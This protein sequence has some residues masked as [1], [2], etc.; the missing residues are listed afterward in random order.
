MHRLKPMP[1]AVSQ[2]DQMFVE[3]RA[4]NKTSKWDSTR[5]VE[6]GRSN[7]RFSGLEVHAAQKVLEARVRAQQ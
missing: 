3:L 5:R 2:R 4:S 1:R 7:L 6:E